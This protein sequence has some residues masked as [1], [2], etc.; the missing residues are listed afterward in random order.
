MGCPLEFQNP[1]SERPPGLR[2]FPSNGLSRA[3]EATPE[4]SETDSV[5]LFVDAFGRSQA[6]SVP[7]EPVGASCDL[8]SQERR[9][10]GSKRS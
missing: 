6:P 8:P 1:A 4:P 2:T 5:S 7:R 10:G 9:H 3:A